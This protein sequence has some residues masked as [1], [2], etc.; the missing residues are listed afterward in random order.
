METELELHSQVFLTVPPAFEQVLEQSSC[1]AN[2][3]VQMKDGEGDHGR[4]WEYVGVGWLVLGLVDGVSS[5]A[6]LFVMATW[7]VFTDEVDA[8]CCIVLL[9]DT[10]EDVVLILDPPLRVIWAVDVKFDEIEVAELFE[11]GSKEVTDGDCADI[12]VDTDKI[13]E[14]ATAASVI[15]NWI[16]STIQRN[17]RSIVV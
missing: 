17:P 14:L 7:V 5:A 9:A 6:V 4:F 15:V 10:A 8:V 3:L 16:T 13:D 11:E 12:G 1:L 2:Q